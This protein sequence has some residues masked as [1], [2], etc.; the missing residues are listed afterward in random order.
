MRK[1]IRIDVNSKNNKFK[2]D[3]KTLGITSENLQGKIIFKPEPF[4]D[5]TCRMYINGRGS[6]LMDKEEDCYTVNILSSLLTEDS[7]DV[8]FKITEP[9]TE[10]GIPIFCSKIMKF[11]VLETIDSSSTIPEDYPSW[12]QVLD[13]MMAQIEQMEEDAED[14]LDEVVGQIQDLTSQYNSNASSKVSDFNSNAASKKEDFNSN[15]T[16]KTSAYNLNAS[17]KLNDLDAY[18]EQ[19]KEEIEEGKDDLIQELSDHESDKESELDSYTNAKK[20]ELNTYT[21]TKKGE[22]DDYEDDKES[23]LSSFASGKTSDFN[24]NASSKIS[25][26]NTNA[27]EKTTEYNSNHTEKLGAYNDNATSKTSSFNDNATAKTSAFNENASDKTDDFD[28][29]ATSKLGAYNSNHTEKLGAYNDNATS[30]TTAFNDN[31]TAKIAEYDAHVAELQSQVDD[32]TTLV[33]TELDTNTVE[34]TEIDV[35]DSA[36][37]RGPVIPGANLEQEQLS[38]KNLWGG[39]EETI[40]NAGITFTTN[41]DG[42]IIANGTATGSTRSTSLISTNAISK[43]YIKT[44]PAGTYIISKNLTQNIEADIVRSNGST[45]ATVPTNETSKIIT[46]TEDTDIFIR[47]SVRVGGTSQNEVI[48]IQLEEG[49]TATDYE[50]YCGGQPSPNPDYPQEIKVVT[51]NNVVKHVGKNLWGGFTPYSVKSYDINY[52]TNADGTV[53]ANGT[54][55]G[56]ATSVTTA[57]ALQRGIYKKLPAGTYSVSGGKSS[58]RFVSIYDL[59]ATQIGR[60]IGNGRTFTLSEDTTII[61]RAEITSGEIADNEIFYIQLEEN[62]TQ[63]PYEPYKEE[64]YE[65][66]M[67]GDNLLVYPYQDAD[68]TSRGIDWNVNDDGTILV[69][70][71]NNDSSASYFN[72]H[73]ANDTLQLKAG[74]YTFSLSSSSNIRCTISNYTTGN[75]IAQIRANNSETTFTLSEDTIIRIILAVSGG[76]TVNNVLVKPQLNPGTTAKRFSQYIA[77]PIELCKI[78]DYSDILFK[79]EVGDENYNAELE[80]GAWYKKG[81]IGKAILDGT[82]YY[83]YNSAIDSFRYNGINNNLIDNT[84]ITTVCTHFIGI[85]FNNRNI[86]TNPKCYFE[87]NYLQLKQSG[88]TDSNIFKAWLSEN[89]VTLYYILATPT[90]T[91][92]T[93]PTL[94]SQLEALR[95]AK[96]FK[97]VN[98]WWTETENLEPNLKGTYKQSNN[99]RLQALEQAV[100]ALGGV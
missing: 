89:N 52:V 82:G 28:D 41:K 5:G 55:T 46:I 44:L 19:K 68:K 26:Y 93:N 20:S 33:E 27:T 35:S 69:N 50:P 72:V 13:S 75:D 6:I 66:N 71:T 60:D 1:D 77:N 49:S 79:N 31:A 10:D 65:V 78:G 96:W 76:L 40:T 18:T 94:I 3:N 91:Q 61:L 100:V 42:S 70:G 8:C 74:T 43:G 45:I 2:I 7:L 38:G 23:E 53:T 30:K 24:T 86:G 85:S 90:Y 83:V 16:N 12:E 58:K 36:E 84:I 59:N 4:V 39:I 37:Y 87:N 17:N 92:I 63:T 9:E 99:L 22:L 56:Y 98:H 51:G 21:T 97:G 25:A 95:K 67:G 11:K 15:A 81:V 62:T 29:N 48:Y 80:D 47:A 57:N 64:E 73:Y 14:R 54:S 34:G 88:Y 32:L